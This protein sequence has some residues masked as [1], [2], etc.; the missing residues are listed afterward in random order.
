MVFAL[1]FLNRALEILGLQ[2]VDR[3]HGLVVCL[4]QWAQPGPL[5]GT[6]CKLDRFVHRKKF[7]RNSS[8]ASL[9]VS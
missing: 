4:Q 1:D 9:T 7:D 8:S 6:G 3:A 5:L 2:N